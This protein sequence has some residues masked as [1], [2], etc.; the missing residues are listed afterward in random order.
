MNIQQIT[1]AEED[2][3][4]ALKRTGFWG[5]EGAGCII[6]ALDTKKFGFPKRGPKVEQPNIYGTVGGVIDRG[7]NPEQAVLREVV[8]EIG[9]SGP[10]KLIP[11]DVFQKDTFRYT[12][13][14][15]LVPKEFEPVLNWES[16]DFV[17]VDFGEW[18]QPLHFGPKGTL[19]KEKVLMKLH[20]LVSGGA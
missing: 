5:D 9:Y 7:E 8:E 16:S 14:L 12:T 13:F 6:F 1:E 11:L 20:H 19:S 3:D 15:G 17:W 4:A 10:L 18:P 2:H